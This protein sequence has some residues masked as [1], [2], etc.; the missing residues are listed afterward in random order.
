MI[1]ILE[2]EHVD[3]KVAIQLCTAAT[4]RKAAEARGRQG[5]CHRG[6]LV[7]AGD[8]PDATRHR[9]K[10]SGCGAPMIDGGRV[11]IMVELWL[12][13]GELMLTG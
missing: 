9:E 8:P 13:T 4:D 10:P 2:V 7:V 1:S 3:L 6:V 5:E 11:Q 12:I